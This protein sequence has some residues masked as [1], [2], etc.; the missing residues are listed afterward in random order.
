[1][2]AFAQSPVA[3][4]DAWARATAPGQTT[5]AVYMSIT[6][7]TG[8]TLTGVSSPDAGAAMLHKTTQMNG[9]SD[10]ADMESLPLPAGKKVTLAPHGMHVMLMDLKH[11]LVAGQSVG[12]DLTF[13]KSPGIHVD[14]PV[15]PI[16]ASAPPA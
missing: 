14:A 13:A 10:M 16:A 8:D 7:P 4:H 6:S 1:M 2:P 5:G 12:V 15:Q 11:P 3:V 9:M